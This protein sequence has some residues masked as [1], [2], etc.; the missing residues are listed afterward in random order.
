MAA[1]TGDGLFTAWTHEPN[2]PRAHAILLPNFGL[3][4]MQG[5][6]PQ[7]VDVAEQ[8]VAKWSRLTPDEVIQTA[9]ADNLGWMAWAWDDNIA[10][11]DSWFA[12]STTGNYNSTADLTTFGKVV[13]ENP[14]YGLLVLARPNTVF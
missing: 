4:A 5:Y 6:M 2:W 11:G 7:M 8:L 1:F 12:L 10:A 14:T 3:K 13:V 9:E